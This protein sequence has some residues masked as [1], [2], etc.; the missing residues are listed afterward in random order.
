[1]AVDEKMLREV[2]AYI[3]TWDDHLEAY[4]GCKFSLEG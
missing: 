1:M 2:T 3:Q 4:F